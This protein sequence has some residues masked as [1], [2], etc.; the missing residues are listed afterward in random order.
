[1]K[2]T[3]GFFSPLTRRRKEMKTNTVNQWRMRTNQSHTGEKSIFN[4]R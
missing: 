4:S 1:M 3:L 2:R